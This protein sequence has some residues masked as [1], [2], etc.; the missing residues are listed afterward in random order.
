MARLS[1]QS[2]VQCYLSLT[3]SG[4]LKISYEAKRIKRP[5]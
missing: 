1:E 2:G 4:G 5:L 3:K